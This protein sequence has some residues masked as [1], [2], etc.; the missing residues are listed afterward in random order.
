[1]SRHQA[2]RGSG[3]Q[4]VP[5]WA[6]TANNAIDALLLILRV[7]VVW[8][9]LTL[10]GLVIVGIFPATCAAGDVMR[11][12]RAGGA[13]PVV[14]TMWATYRR[15]LVGA[16]LRLLPLGLVQ[17]SGVSTIFLALR[18]GV[19]QPWMVAPVMILAACAVGWATASAAVLATVPR[20]RR[21]DLLVSLRVSLL[22]PGA[23]P[24]AAAL[25]VLSVAA[26]VLASYLVPPLGALLGAGAAVQ[27]ASTLVGRRAEELLTHHAPGSG[28]PSAGD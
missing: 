20:L 21:Q 16:N 5:G 27:A 19:P 8:W 10:L 11:D 23:V 1:M 25:T 2:Q 9:A 22:A 13:A 28:V 26:I 4:Q 3:P 6:M 14:R 17:L 15:E 7:T 18:G 12:R 24:L